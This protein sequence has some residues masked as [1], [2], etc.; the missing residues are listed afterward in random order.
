MSDYPEPLEAV[1]PPAAFTD[2]AQTVLADQTP[3]D[4]LASMSPQARWALRKAGIAT[5]EGAAARPDEELLAIPGFG[6]SSLVRLRE[7]ERDPSALPPP[8][9]RFLSE[10]R[11]DRVHALYVALR[12]NGQPAEKARE[13]AVAE[14]DAL[15]AQMRS[16]A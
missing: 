11:E 7:W 8:A 3:V 10:T 13:L 9:G 1:E 12:A 16:G 6:E 15:T 14:V 2:G 5:L 4:R